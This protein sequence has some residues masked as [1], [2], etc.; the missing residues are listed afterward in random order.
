MNEQTIPSPMENKGQPL[1]PASILSQILIFARHSTGIDMF[2]EKLLI[3]MV[4]LTNASAA[5]TFKK[6]S[7][8][9]IV[10]LQQYFQPVC[11]EYKENILLEIKRTLLSTR[12]KEKISL[13]KIQVSEGK[14]FYFLITPFSEERQISFAILLDAN[15]VTMVEPFILII[16]L[17]SG[18]SHLFLLEQNSAQSALLTSQTAFII[19]LMNGA[20]QEMDIEG[21]SYF[22]VNQMQQKL[23][24]AQV[25]LGYIH[26]SH[27]RLLAISGMAK[28]NKRS[29]AIHAFESAMEET[30]REG[31]AVQF[32]QPS[33]KKILQSDLAHQQLAEINQSASIF[34]VP[35]S[36]Q[37]EIV[38]VW[39]F[40]WKEEHSLS[41][42]EKNLAMGCSVSVAPLLK[43]LLHNKKNLLRKGLE[44]CFKAC[45][46]YRFLF[47]LLFFFDFMVHDSSF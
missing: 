38:G 27:A 26:K 40:V 36:I 9:E 35:L 12:E 19:E 14:T 8:A 20:T 28:Y 6:N 7:P 30:M 29:P 39:I 15:V 32:P 25:V 3:L 17:V 16:Q 31:V 46:S 24:C 13:S 1:D 10:G 5:C 18:Y 42:T 22:L 23:G 33:E 44:A 47:V 34:S 4:R 21:A 2:V 45:Y 37:K 11:L 43:L 41:P